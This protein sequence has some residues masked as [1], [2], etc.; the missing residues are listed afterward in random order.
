MNSG[1]KIVI[2][3]SGGVD[4]SVAAYL[5]KKQGYQVIDLEK[6]L[7]PN[8]DILCNSVIKFR[9]FVEYAEKHF[10]PNFIATGHYAKIIRGSGE[11]ASLKCIHFGNFLT[12]P[13]D[14]SKDQTYFLCQIDRKLLTKIIF[15]L[16][17][18][19]KKKVRQIAEEIGL[20]NSKK[21]DSTG[22]CFIGEQ[23]FTN[24]LANYFP[25]KEGE[26]IDIDSK[27]ILGKHFGTYYFTIGQRRNL[28]LSGQK[29]PLYVVGKN[30]AKN[31]IYVTSVEEEKLT[32]FLDNQNIT[33]KFRYRQPDISV[34]IFPTTNFEE[35]RV[36]F[37]EK[38]R[39]VTPG[40][41]AVFYHNDI[42]LGGGVIFNTERNKESGEPIF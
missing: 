41:Y 29:K 32:T 35:S 12:K 33:A 5:L 23:K 40:Q 7:T 16:A 8:P 13:Q 19:T 22:I 42:C 17:D 38:Q 4:S 27:K 11:C 1:K 25:K 14:K 3:L 21:K 24:F 6:G 20:I 34:K 26:I 15:P 30:L 2:G 39:A 36:E 10:K 18:L 28:S 37:S 31:I 9:N